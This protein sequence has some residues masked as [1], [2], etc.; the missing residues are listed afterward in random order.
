MTSET[1]THHTAAGKTRHKDAPA[2]DGSTLEMP[3]QAELAPLSAESSAENP[4]VSAPD[5][6]CAA[7]PPENP[8]MSE[9]LEHGERVAA[10]AE[11][12]FQDL[13][14]LHK[15]EDVWGRR[16]LLAA[17]FHDIGL[18]GGRK[19][20]HKRSMRLIEE[21]LGSM[22]DEDR[23]YVALL[24]RYHRKARPSRRHP[25]FA[26]LKRRDREALRKTVAL[27]RIADALDCTHSGVIKHLAVSVKK[28][29]VLIALQSLGDCS[30]ERERLLDTG[31]LFADIFNRKLE[32]ACLSE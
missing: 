22:P 8:T 14:E 9:A 19:G 30:A 7:P 6:A 18:A 2:T 24:A 3:A 20:H 10:I 4:T 27:L 29:K 23:P 15:L 26:E 28:R 16:L 17:R 32:C 25:R 13:A 21:D 11:V 1:Q 12:L 31:S 5:D